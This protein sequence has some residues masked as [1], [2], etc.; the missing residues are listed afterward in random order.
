MG[1]T[2]IGVA[3]CLEK[4]RGCPL[5]SPRLAFFTFVNVSSYRVLRP[6]ETDSDPI[7]AHYENRPFSE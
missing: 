6:S 3:Y 7:L 4:T 1:K 5:R 2:G